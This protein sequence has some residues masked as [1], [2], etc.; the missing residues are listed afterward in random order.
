MYNIAGQAELLGSMFLLLAVNS[1]LSV[2]K[3]ENLVIIYSV[4]AILSKETA[5]FTLLFCACLSYIRH[6]K[7]P[8][9]Y[10]GAAITIFYLRFYYVTSGSNFKQFNVLDNPIAY[11]S[12]FKTKIKLIL[13]CNLKNLQLLFWPVNLCHDWSVAEVTKFLNFW[14]SV[15]LASLVLALAIFSQKPVFSHKKL[16]LFWLSL[17][18]FL[19]SHFLSFFDKHV[20]FFIAERTLYLAS[21]F[22]S[23]L[24]SQIS[25][26]LIQKSSTFQFLILLIILLFVHKL[27][28]DSHRWKS[29]FN[30]FRTDLSRS[31][32]KGQ[33]NYFSLNLEESESNLDAF[34]AKLEQENEL[35]SAVYSRSS[36]VD[37]LMADFYWQIQQNQT[38][39]IFHY[40]SAI[41]KNVL[42]LEA[43]EKL[44]ILQPDDLDLDLEILAINSSKFKNLQISSLDS[45][46][47]NSNKMELLKNSTVSISDFCYNLPQNFLK[48]YC[49][50]V[51]EN[52]D[53]IACFIG[54]KYLNQLT[55]AE[56]LQVGK[57]CRI[58]VLSS[59]NL[60]YQKG[61]EHNKLN[62]NDNQLHN[63]TMSD[64]WQDL[65]ILIY[66]KLLKI[67]HDKNIRS[68]DLLTNIAT[69]YQIL[70]VHSSGLVFFRCRF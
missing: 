25:C 40:R 59:T 68:S 5:Y 14:P 61:L 31:S 18:L 13:S 53:K 56:G 20:G 60:L 69:Y 38:H 49:Y 50:S 63:H 43:Y 1:Q 51:I 27:Q 36:N 47:E 23:Y 35:V 17:S 62:T 41:S 24:L 30:L 33:I 57:F 28:N 48:I 9:Q 64:S 42:S 54:E 7:I 6:Q 4:L 70:R 19:S 10:L 39:A 67:H 15:L 11:V 52:N 2:K 45:I 46:A 16:T 66:Q 37:L 8:L 44:Q 34:Y 65:P 29:N 3:S 32:I 22:S 26:Q 21:I 12:D 55:Y 58:S